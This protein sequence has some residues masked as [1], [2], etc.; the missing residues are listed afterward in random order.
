MYIYP[1]I[2][3]IENNFH[4]LMVKIRKSNKHTWFS[5]SGKFNH[6]QSFQKIHHLFLSIW[7][8]LRETI[9]ILVLPKIVLSE[10]PLHTH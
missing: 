7:K 4:H 10:Y 2:Y 6:I 8:L 5:R 3:I 9:I 1:Y